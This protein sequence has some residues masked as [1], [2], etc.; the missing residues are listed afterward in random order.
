[1]RL[2]GIF[3]LLAAG[4]TAIAGHERG[5]GRGRGRGR[6]R[7]KRQ[8]DQE[9]AT[10]DDACNIG[11]CSVWGATIGG[12]GSSYTT[13][14]TPDE[15]A[16]AVSGTQEGVIIVEGDLVSAEGRV[17]E[18]GSSKS[19]VGNPGS[20]A[21][22]LLLFTQKGNSLSG[23]TLQFSGSRN[24]ILRNLRIANSPGNPYA[25][26]SLNAARSIWIDHC[27]ISGLQGPPYLLSIVNGTDYVT[28]THN[29]FHSRGETIQFPAVNVGHEAESA[30]DASAKFHISFARNW[31]ATLN[32]SVE[33]RF[34]TGHFLN[35]YFDAVKEGI[36]ILSGGKVSV[37][38]SVFEGIGINKGVKSSDETGYAA[39][40]DSVFVGGQYG[41]PEGVTLGDEVE[42]VEY[43]Y[44]WYLWETARVKDGV[45]RWAGQSLEFLVWE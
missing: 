4:V 29:K 11:F 35:N 31:F 30:S 21:F 34:G 28:V 8:S 41:Q 39:I 38:G 13:V 19:I 3:L 27:D 42:G 14:R 37:E 6:L 16:A 10:Y 2:L 25:A 18:I 20:C 12:W 45:K 1:M 15:F 23:I 40:R 5:H 43:P 17:I 33:F 32:K 44:D 26:I 22:S 36:D 9:A 7:V 24:V